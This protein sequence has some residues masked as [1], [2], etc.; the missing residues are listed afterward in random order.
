MSAVPVRQHVHP[1]VLKPILDVYRHV[2][3]GIVIALGHTI[4]VLHPVLHPRRELG[5]RRCYPTRYR[6]RN[7][8]YGPQ[9]APHTHGY[10]AKTRRRNR[11]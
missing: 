1:D 9:P 10:Y 7:R 4:E 8:S 11:R 3:E 2:G 5:C 6:R